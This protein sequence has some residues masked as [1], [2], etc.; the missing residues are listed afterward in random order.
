MTALDSE[1]ET[2]KIEPGHDFAPLQIY[3]LSN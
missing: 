3:V 1:T 2:F